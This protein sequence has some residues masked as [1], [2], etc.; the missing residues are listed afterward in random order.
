MYVR[1]ANDVDTGR[2]VPGSTP[3]P[4]G[5]PRKAIASLSAAVRDALPPE[6]IVAE[7]E[8]LL[9]DPY[10]DPMKRLEVIRWAT[11]RGYGRVVAQTELTVIAEP[12]TAL[13]EREDHLQLLNRMTI[14]ELEE[15]STAQHTVARLV[16]LA[17]SRPEP[18][19]D[20]FGRP[21]SEGAVDAVWTEPGASTLPPAAP[22]LALTD[23]GEML[24]MPRR[25]DDLCR[26]LN[27][28]GHYCPKEFARC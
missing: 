12:S 18:V 7:I 6:K 23:G 1:M 5:R 24:G 8:R 25:C 3:N 4:G 21:V 17:R 26:V 2:F 28:H 27:A 10:S 19:L 20:R 16:A 15:L 22:T 13:A 9:S 14:A 11:D